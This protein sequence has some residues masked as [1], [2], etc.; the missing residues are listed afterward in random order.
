MRE[1]RQWEFDEDDPPQE[2]TQKIADDGAR[3]PEPFWLG[4]L[5]ALG[6]GVVVFSLPFIVIFIIWMVVSV[7]F[8][9]MNR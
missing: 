9:V 3:G 2:T 4:F 7:F 5:K 8:D 1:R 6:V